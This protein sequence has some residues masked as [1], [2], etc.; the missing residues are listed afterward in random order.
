MFRIFLLFWVL[1][2]S[3]CAARAQGTPPPP[4]ADTKQV[5]IIQADKLDRDELLGRTRLTGNVVLRQQHTLLSL[6]LIH[7]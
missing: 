1:F 4:Q 6:S 2:G 5:E 3:V 7:I